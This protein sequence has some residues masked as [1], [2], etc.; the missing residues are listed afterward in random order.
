MLSPKPWKADAIIRLGL[1]VLICVYAG[2]LILSVQHYSVPGQRPDPRFFFPLAAAALG[3]LAATLILIRKRWPPEALSRRLV[4]LAVCAYGAASGDV[5]AAAF[6]GGPGGNFD[7]RVVV[8]ELQF[9]GAGLILI[10]CFLREH[11]IGWVP[12]FRIFGAAPGQSG[13]FGRT[14][15]PDFPAGRLGVGDRPARS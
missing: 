3:G 4:V 14:R 13:G 15:R 11:Q 6:R 9:Q 5:G 12:A 8:A 7:W 10:A 1:S 2:S